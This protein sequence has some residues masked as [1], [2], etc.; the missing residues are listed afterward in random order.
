MLPRI[1]R[2]D[3][4]WTIPLFLQ[5]KK[6]NAVTRFPLER[7]L[8]VYTSLLLDMIL[9]V[10]EYAVKK[11]ARWSMNSGHRIFQSS[12]GSKEQYS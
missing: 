7:K 5:F 4:K 11:K 6:I 3:T 8:D 1:M 10:F 2:V 12:S 9:I